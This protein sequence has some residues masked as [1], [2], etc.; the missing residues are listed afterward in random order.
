MTAA[1][2]GA[3]LTALE[4]VRLSWAPTPDD[5]WQP[6][7]ALH[8]DGLHEAVMGELRRAVADAEAVT[9]GG[10][11][12]GV[13]VQGP[14]GSGKTHLLGQVREHVQRSGGYFFLIRLLDG[15]DFWRSVV[16]GMLE[17]LARPTPDQAS[18]LVDLIDALAREADLGPDATAALTG[19]A[20]LTRQ[21]LEDFVEA[22]YRRHPRHRRRSQHVLRALVLR[23]A[24]D[25]GLQDLGDT[26][27][28]LDPGL[29]DELAE[30]GIRQVRL[31]HEEIAQNISRLLA[32]RGPTVMAIDQIDTLVAV[33]AR[34]D[35]QATVQEL[36]H[37]L[38]AMRETMARTVC[39][40]ACISAS[41]VVLEDHV[42]R[43]V[44]DRFRVPPPLQRPDDPGFGPR[45][46]EKRFRAGYAS[47]GFTP[48]YPSWP[49]APAAFDEFTRFTPRELLMA[50]D[51]HVN[52]CLRSGEITELRDLRPAGPAVND[53]HGDDDALSGVDTRFADLRAAADPSPALDADA[54]DGVVPR[55]LRVA[56]AAWLDQRGGAGD[57]RVDPPPSA[58]PA[59]HGRIRRTIDA[60]TDREFSWGIRSVASLNAV[61]ALSRVRKAATAAGVSTRT[62]DH[63]LV[64]LRSTPWPSGPKTR[65]T[66]DEVVANGG[67]L[68]SWT[69]DEV[70]TLMALESLLDE[71]PDDLI[72]WLVSRRPV[73]AV[74]FLDV[75]DAEPT[76]SLPAPEPAHSQ[77][78]DLIEPAAD[79][80]PDTSPSEGTQA[81][82]ASVGTP[83]TRTPADSVAVGTAQGRPVTIELAALRK[84]TALFA[85]SGSGKTVLIRRLVEEC[86]IAGVSSIVLDVNN[87]LARMGEP[88][89]DGSRTWTADDAD[90]AR[91]YFDGTEVVVYTPGRATG[92]PLSFQPLP[93]FRGLT[94]DPEEFDADEFEAAVD[95]AVASLAP[96]VNAE[97][98]SATAKRRQAML[99]QAVR[100]FGRR[101]GG[102]LHDLIDMLAELPPD[103]SDLRQPG[104]LAADIADG[105]RVAMANDTM[106][107]GDAD[108][109]D[110]ATLL[111]PSHGRRAR[112]SVINLAGLRSDERRDNFVNQL[113]M[114]LFAHIRRHPAG[115]RPLGGLFVMD[116]AQNFAPAGRFTACTQSTLA[117]ASQ[118]RKYGLGLVFATQA[119]KG[120]N[121]KIPGNSST[122]FFGKLTSP[123][124]IAAA[125]EVASA[126]GSVI[127]DVGRLT[128]GR[129]YAS[130]DGA[131]FVDL[132]TP[133]CLSHHPASP[134]TEDEVLHIARGGD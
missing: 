83:T 74:G 33:A 58:K 84:H 107:G 29:E 46:L 9:D 100:W 96:R 16:V 79:Q 116:E 114:A 81:A 110:P 11:P 70:R 45:M 121:N 130:V 69:P 14:A 92:R 7:E 105:L 59:L 118:A 22:V 76:D 103:V 3:A 2:A 30:W 82:P 125:R 15:T 61:A 60:E 43:S 97:G 34:S 64:L 26:F 113:Q 73:D 37:G 27:L 68:A 49:I 104:R 108:A 56:F 112:V 21:V 5:V 17:D 115:D 8:V 106:L 62:P 42:V 41:W 109:M 31:G 19:N 23:A 63:C 71:R 95:S 132:Q 39:V 55:L 52:A 88:W 50:A 91:R 124:Q 67:V 66:L 13:V 35:G 119:P 47:V 131:S 90:R 4:T 57:F 24:A 117:L 93:D 99:N 65:Q 51:R 133:L 128:T 1:D 20:P 111:T 28:H 53:A 18:Q 127:G 75:L 129:F 86:A 36:A 44:S 40:V 38:M 85:G 120:L 54:E 134:P 94:D 77:T 87:D 102:T 6:Q 25:F 12:L 89:P 122:Q 32:L 10:S 48:P 72:P 123:V 98:S 80:T 101:G 126:K 78:A